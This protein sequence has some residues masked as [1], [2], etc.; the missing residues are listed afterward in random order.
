MPNPKADE[1]CKGQAKELGSGSEGGFSFRF[2]GLTGS[3]AFSLIGFI[4]PG[5]FYLRLRPLY[6]DDGRRRFAHVPL[7]IV[8]LCVGLVGGSF[9]LASELL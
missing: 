6:N 1:E 3:L 4:L 9:G 8:L 7:A 2:F 5:L